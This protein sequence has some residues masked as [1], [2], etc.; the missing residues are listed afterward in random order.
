MNNQLLWIVFSF[1][2]LMLTIFHFYQ[3][4][5]KIPKLKNK[6]E[7]KTINGVKMGMSEFVEDFGIYIDDSNKLNRTIN[8]VQA[9][10]YFA[11]FCTSVYSYL[12]SNQLV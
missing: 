10:G 1:I 7:I 9:F 4:T 8:V 6:G 12:L 3:A 5:R 2:F 11:A